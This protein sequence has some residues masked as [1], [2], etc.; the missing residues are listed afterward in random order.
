[1]DCP[2][3][4]TG[5][6]AVHKDLTVFAS[7]SRADIRRMKPVFEGFAHAH[8]DLVQVRQWHED[9]ADG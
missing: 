6:Q 8:A 5:A 4:G 1:M 2:L 9:E 3:S 7:G